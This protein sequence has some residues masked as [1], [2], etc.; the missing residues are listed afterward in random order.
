MIDSLLADKI[1]VNAVGHLFSSITAG[2]YDTKISD[3]IAYTKARYVIGNFRFNGDI[4]LGGQKLTEMLQY[5]DAILGMNSIQRINWL[6][7]FSDNTVTLSTDRIKIPALPDDKILTLDFYL[8]S[9][10]ATY[11]D[12]TIDGQSF[13]DVFFDTGYD[14][15]I[16]INEKKQGI[17]IIL[18]ESDY[19]AYRSNLKFLSIGLD[20]K[21]RKYILTDSFQINDFTIP[22]L[23]GM[24]ADLGISKTVITANFVQ[25][26]RMMYVD[27]KNKKIQLYVS[28]SDSA[29][30]QR[31]D[32]Q[33][34][35]REMSP[36]VQGN[37]TIDVNLSKFNL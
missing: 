4:S 31:K 26:F 11:K 30:Y 23:I 6:F 21:D 37:D 33:D 22:S 16:F 12:I 1:G 14:A 32:I 18:S 27:S 7:N 5:S 9:D 10:S 17:D 8:G 34:F 20:I 13:Q 2:I 35:I 19:I 24:K 3:S 36:H 15:F 29:R 28:P 25:R